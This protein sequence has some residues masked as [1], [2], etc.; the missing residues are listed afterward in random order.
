MSKILRYAGV[1]PRSSPAPV[2]ETMTK[3]AYDLSSMG[4]H[5]SSGWGRG[6]DTAFAK[7]APVHMQVQWV[8]W[9]GFNGSNEHAP[10]QD[11][12]MTPELMKIASEHHPYWRSMKLITQ[13]LMCRNVGIL[14]GSKLDQQVDMLVYWQS[15]KDENSFESGTNHTRRVANTWGIPSFNIRTESDQKA[16]CEFVNQREDALNV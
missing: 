5:L 4:W 2:L 1:G 6:A 14:L 11:C 15:E 12:P 10:F 3:L 8:P 16:L 9:Y 13:R 7:G